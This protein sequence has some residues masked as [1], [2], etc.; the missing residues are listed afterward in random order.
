MARDDSNDDSDASEQTAREQFGPLIPETIDSPE[1]YDPALVPDGFIPE[2]A[3]NGR[4]FTT[5]AWDGG[6]SDLEAA[7]ELYDTDAGAPAVL[8]YASIQ[9][10][11]IA[12]EGK[13]VDSTGCS[14]TIEA[15]DGTTRTVYEADAD[16]RVDA[17]HGTTGTYVGRLCELRLTLA[18]DDLNSTEA[19]DAEGLNSTQETSA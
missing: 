3:P 9:A 19:G 2:T 10:G 4:R 11:A 17:V 7:P 15:A 1:E 16:G 18:A 14:V 12:F 13:I 6:L 5:A 8:V